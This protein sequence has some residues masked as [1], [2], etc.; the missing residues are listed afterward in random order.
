MKAVIS[1]VNI[2]NEPPSVFANIFNVAKGNRLYTIKYRSADLTTDDT[3]KTLRIGATIGLRM[4]FSRNH[5]DEHLYLND[6]MVIGRIKEVVTPNIVR[7]TSLID[8][9]DLKDLDK[10]DPLRGLAHNGEN[11]HGYLIKAEA[12]AMTHYSFRRLDL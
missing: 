8:E 7:I 2:H 11:V 4:P 12:E 6:R 3:W 5:L 1:E 9:D 10:Q